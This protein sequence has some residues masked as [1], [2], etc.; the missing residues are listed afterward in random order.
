MPTVT[1][2]IAR[3]A[4]N[5]VPRALLGSPMSSYSVRTAM[6]E[7]KLVWIRPSASG[8]TDRLLVNLL[9]QDLYR[10]TLARRE[11]PEEH[12]RPFHVFVD[13]LISIDGASGS[14]L[15]GISEELRSFGARLH[16]MTQLLQQVSTAT[17]ESIVQN[18]STLSSTA[19][20]RDAVMLIAKEWDD[21]VDP[22]EITTLPR[23]HHYLTLTSNGRRLG[24]LRI[25]GPSWRR[26]SPAW[27]GRRRSRRCSAQPT[28][29][30][31]RPRSVNWPSE[32]AR[33]TPHS[34][35]PREDSGLRRSPGEGTGRGG[36]GRSGLPGG[37]L[38]PPGG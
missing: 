33:T 23:F 34:P 22:G 25:R 16:T 27:P 11:M 4:A 36:R 5:K 14:V 20:S 18:S 7:G 3:L 30:S 24:P 31:Q 35:G 32:P 1:N 15:A 10:A 9:F 12:R 29:I 8:P 13:E 26:S 21:L 38:T 28:P 17:R 19:G 6:D 37:V 2:P